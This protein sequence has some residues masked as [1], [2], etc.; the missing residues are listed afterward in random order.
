MHDSEDKV[1][2]I[3][4]TRE[5]KAVVG[6][7]T[8]IEKPMKFNFVIEWNEP[9]EQV[10]EAMTSN[11]K[12]L[13]NLIKSPLTP[14]EERQLNEIIENEEQLD[15]IEPFWGEFVNWGSMQKLLNFDRKDK[16]M[17]KK[18]IND[19]VVNNNCHKYPAQQDKI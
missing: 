6:G 16:D 14:D 11:A 13:T 7:K 3:K 17:T 1:Q 9:E 4:G 2:V 8:V 18:W 5:K 15:K 10:C 12:E 19:K